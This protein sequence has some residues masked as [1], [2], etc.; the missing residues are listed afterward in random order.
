LN[1]LQDKKCIQE[2]IDIIQRFPE[3]FKNRT[4]II[5]LKDICEGH[6][7]INSYAGKYKIS[8]FW[9]EE[10]RFI[11]SSYA[12]N[13]MKDYKAKNKIP[14]KQLQNDIQKLTSLI[15][16]VLTSIEFIYTETVFFQHDHFLNYLMLEDLKKFFRKNFPEDE[17]GKTESGWM[18]S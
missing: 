3:Q 15:P 14:T 1:Y 8:E 2:L 5:C 12:N 17:L 16:N 4:F 11:E 10:L 9:H 13:K 6:I 18:G 7:N